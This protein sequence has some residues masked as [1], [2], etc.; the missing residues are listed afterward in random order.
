MVREHARNPL[1]RVEVCFVVFIFFFFG[2]VLM[3]GLPEV[4]R[5][6]GVLCRNVSEGARAAL[7][8]V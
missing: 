2:H 4:G 3:G 7:L 6:A 8:F 5:G 1:H